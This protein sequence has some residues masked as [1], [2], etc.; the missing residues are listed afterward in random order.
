MH[1]QDHA[2]EL[3]TI[4]AVAAFWD[5][6]SFKPVKFSLPNF[7][8][9]N[10]L[11]NLE[12]QPRNLSIFGVFLLQILK[13][14]LARRFLWSPATHCIPFGSRFLLLLVS[15]HGLYSFLF[16]NDQ[17]FHRPASTT[18]ALDDDRWSVSTD[19]WSESGSVGNPDSMSIHSRLSYNSENVSRFYCMEK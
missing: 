12:L 4:Y 5:S 8:I 19:R 3:F 17:F 6:Q 9:S 14:C 15:T 7:G 1:F 2:S 10:H 11:P 18:S 13:N 16:S